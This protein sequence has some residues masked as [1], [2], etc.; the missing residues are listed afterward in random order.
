MTD[1]FISKRPGR[2]SKIYARTLQLLGAV[3]LFGRHDLAARL[4]AL[5]TPF[6]GEDGV[7]EALLS[8]ADPRR[9]AVDEWYFAEPYSSLYD[10][11]HADDPAQQ[12]AHLR[13]YLASWHPAL[14]QEDWF[15]GHLRTQGLGGY[16]GLWAFEAAAAAQRLGL[17]RGALAHWLMPPT[18]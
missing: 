5:Q 8:A 10:C 12:L 1:P 16:Y 13:H 11:L 6:D 3:L 9:P 17:E 4:A 7:Y 18:P 15:N 2:V 14:V